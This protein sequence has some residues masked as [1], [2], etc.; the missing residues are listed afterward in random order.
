M[1]P[2]ILGLICVIFLSGCVTREQAD[3]KLAKGCAA[4]AELFL[5]DLFK[6]KE[7]K[8]QKFKKSDEFGD[9]YREVMLSVVETDEWVDLDKEYK[10]VFAEEFGTMNSTHRATIYQIKVNDQ[11]Y[12]IEDGEILG[13]MQIH[14]QLTETVQQA[15]SE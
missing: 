8:D 4:G 7:V 6:I 9:S 15:M 1:R 11:T 10:C 13:D 5:D 14:I 2:L 3:K 12:G